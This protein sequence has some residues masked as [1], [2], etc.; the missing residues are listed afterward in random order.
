[1]ILLSGSVSASKEPSACLER[2]LYLMQE[3]LTVAEL[4]KARALWLHF[5]GRGVGTGVKAHGR[6]ASLQEQ[7]EEVVPV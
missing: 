4:P 7:Q 2:T 1:M 3:C 5:E 6:A